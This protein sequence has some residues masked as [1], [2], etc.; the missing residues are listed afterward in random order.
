MSK[1]CANCGQELLEHAKFCNRCGVSSTEN[2]SST[3]PM[4]RKPATAAPKKSNIRATTLISIVLTITLT[5]AMLVLLLYR[6]PIKDMKNITLDD[7]N[8]MKLGTAVSKHIEDA[9]WDKQMLGINQYLVTISGYSDYWKK[10]MSLTFDVRYSLKGIQ[11]EP[12]YGALNGDGFSNDF[13]ISLAMAVLYDYQ[14]D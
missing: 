9:K 5:T 12:V 3:E 2:S 7:W 14:E 6:T 10:D 8:E 13:W 1:K 4:P 11:A